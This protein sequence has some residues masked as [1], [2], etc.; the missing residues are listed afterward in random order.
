MPQLDITYYLV[1][2]NG[3][4]VLDEND[5][6]IVI[7]ST[8]VPFDYRGCRLVRKRMNGINSFTVNEQGGRWF[9]RVNKHCLLG[10]YSTKELAVGAVVGAFINSGAGDL[11]V[12]SAVFDDQL[13][14][15]VS[16]IGEGSVIPV[17][18]SYFSSEAINGGEIGPGSTG[19]F[20][21][22]SDNQREAGIVPDFRM[23]QVMGILGEE[24]STAWTL[25]P[26]NAGLDSWYSFNPF[27]WNGSDPLPNMATPAS[28]KS[29]QCSSSRCSV[30]WSRGGNAFVAWS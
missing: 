28:R 16:F 11:S 20:Y 17:S 23:D 5:D 30:R 3:E 7:S 25:Y 24:T 27:S 19:S 22:S 12:I 21:R 10:L 6:R 18:T 29:L 9:A 8:A 1:D 14:R 13:S 26:E 2:E 15:G 4:Y